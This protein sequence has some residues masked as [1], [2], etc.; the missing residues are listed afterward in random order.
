MASTTFTSGTVIPSEW[1]N[2]VNQTVH[3]ANAPFGPTALERPRTAADKIA[4]RV[5]VKDFG[6]VCDG[7]TIDTEAV[8]RALDYCASQSTHWP[9]LIIPGRCA[10]NASL[11]IDRPVDS[12][13]SEFRIVGEGPAAGFVAAAEVPFF[14]S[15]LP[16]T[17]PSPVSEFITFENIRFSTP[18]PFDRSLVLSKKFLR[19]K[20]LNCY[21]YIVRCIESEGFVQTMYFLGC[22]IRNNAENFINS[23]GLFDVTFDGCIIENG[24]TIVRSVDVNYGTSALRFINN[25]IE[26]IGTSVV[27][28]AGVNGFD[29]I[30]NYIEANYSPEFNFFAGAPNRSITVIGNYINNVAGPTMYYGPTDKVFSS[31]NTAFPNLLH[32][33]A[34]QVGDLV[35]CGDSC[36]GGISDSPTV[37][38]INGVYRAGNVP[39]TWTDSANQLTKSAAGEV[40]IGSAP[41]PGSRLFVRGAGQTAAGYAGVFADSAGNPIASFRNDRAI[42]MPALANCA[43]D[44]AAAT[45]GV[46]VGGLYRNGS[47]VQVRVA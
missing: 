1:L 14:D 27:V 4:E 10:L 44:A 32:S 12:T 13:S 5:S 25:V 34:I 15:S 21:F 18:S 11:R 46:P 24:N 28:A 23:R 43:N 19:I 42:L 47:V 2:E 7:T 39:A 8:Q 33:N 17:T 6:A 16:M 41:A 3:R 36:E 37:A 30:G 22:N 29:L 31:G 45:A 40:G 26:G 38:V 35:S 20:F 9:T